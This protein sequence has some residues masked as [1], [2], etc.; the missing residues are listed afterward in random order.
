MKGKIF[1]SRTEFEAHPTVIRK[2]RKSEENGRGEP[3][4][5]CFLIEI[6]NSMSYL[7]YGVFRFYLYLLHVE[8]VLSIGVHT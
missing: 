6:P 8:N 3:G 1:G 2:Y 7:D 4:I 5:F